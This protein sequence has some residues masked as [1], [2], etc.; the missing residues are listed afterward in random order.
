MWKKIILS[1][2]QNLI[3]IVIQQMERINHFPGSLQ[4]KDAWKAQT[5]NIYSIYISKRKWGREI[6]HCHFSRKLLITRRKEIMRPRTECSLPK[7]A[8]A[9]FL[10]DCSSVALRA[11]A[12]KNPVSAIANGI[13]C[14]SSSLI[15]KKQHI[16]FLKA[17]SL[18][19]PIIHSY[20]CG[21]WTD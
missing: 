4:P 12:L 6:L 7:W 8:H 17:A 18:S 15:A 1:L 21:A 14:R 2:D 11:K 10:Q 13:I 3:W 19:P 20:P 5:K 9:G 16:R